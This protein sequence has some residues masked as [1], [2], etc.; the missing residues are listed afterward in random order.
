MFYIWQL[1]YHDLKYYVWRSRLEFSAFFICVTNDYGYDHS[2]VLLSFMTYEQVCNQ[3]NTMG[4]TCGEGIAYPPEHLNSVP[5]F[6]ESCV[7]RSFVFCEMFCRSLFGLF[8]LPT[9]FTVLSVLQFTVFDYLFGIFKLFFYNNVAH[10][11]RLHILL[12]FGKHL[13]DGIISLKWEDLGPYY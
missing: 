9:V 7:A 10:A 6:R 1:L 2:P 5:V 12:I 4:A 13:H 3:S 8:H 11:V